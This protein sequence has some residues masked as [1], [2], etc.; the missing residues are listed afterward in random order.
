MTNVL[1]ATT[2]TGSVW[3]RLEQTIVWATNI[4]LFGFLIGLVAESAVIK[5]VSTPVLGVALLAAVFTRLTRRV[6]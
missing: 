3:D 1:L 6:A 5:Q 2:G 4:A